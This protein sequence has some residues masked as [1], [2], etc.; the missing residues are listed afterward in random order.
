MVPNDAI[1]QRN[2]K[3]KEDYL[4]YDAWFKANSSRLMKDAEQILGD[5]LNKFLNLRFNQISRPG[6]SENPQ[7]IFQQ[8][9]G[10]I[11]EII[12]CFN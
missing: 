2:L 7:A 12:T 8:Y 5:R 11:N 6:D 3:L 9:E 10:L 4:K 1:V